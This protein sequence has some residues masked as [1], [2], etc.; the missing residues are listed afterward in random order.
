MFAYE[1][2]GVT[3]GQFTTFWKGGHSSRSNNRQVDHGAQEKL[4]SIFSIGNLWYYPPTH[5][6]ETAMFMPIETKQYKKVVVEETRQVLKPTL[7]NRN[8]TVDEIVTRE[9][10]KLSGTAQEKCINI[11][12]GIEEPAVRILYLFDIL[13]ERYRKDTMP[14]AAGYDYMRAFGF[15]KCIKAQ[16]VLPGSVA[17]E[18]LQYATTRDSGIIRQIVGEMAKLSGVLPE[19]AIFDAPPYSKLPALWP[20]RIMTNERHSDASLYVPKQQVAIPGPFLERY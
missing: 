1:A 14:P 20:I 16:V 11:K 9:V 2:A 3:Q 15:N 12:S 19:K 10:D 17:N 6:T 18:L 4:D 8:R 13:S 5:T 7:F